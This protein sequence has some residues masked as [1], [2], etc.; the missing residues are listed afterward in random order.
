MDE[1][2]LYSIFFLLLWLIISAIYVFLIRKDEDSKIEVNVRNNAPFAFNKKE[3]AFPIHPKYQINKIQTFEEMVQSTKTQSSKYD[4]LHDELFASNPLP[5][6]STQTKREPKMVPYNTINH[7]TP[8][9]QVFNRR[10]YIFIIVSISFLIA[11]LCRITYKISL[12]ISLI[13]YS[14][15]LLTYYNNKDVKDGEENTHE[16][17]YFRNNYKSDNNPSSWFS[18]EPP[19]DLNIEEQYESVAHDQPYQLADRPRSSLRNSRKTLTD[20]DQKA[21]ECLKKLGITTVMYN[22]YLSNFKSMISQ[23]VLTK[24]IQKLHSEESM[25]ITM[26]SVPGYEHCRGYIIQRIKA[27]A[28]SQYLS[29]HFGDCGDYYEGREWTTD[30][31]S[32]NQIVMHILSVWFSYFMGG[33]NP[34]RFQNLFYEKYLFIKREPIFDDEESVLLCSD[35]YCNFYVYTKYGDNIPEKFYTF[36]GRDSMYA[37]LMLFFW[38][39]MKKKNFLLDAADF[40]ETP[41][42]ID[43]IFSLNK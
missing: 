34:D 25:Y 9:K 42:C 32:D 18:K 17:E 26:L 23:T 2:Y 24:L 31:P 10:I 1:F 33:K 15:A 12:T 38:F 8:P 20:N 3:S 43:R 36:L 19:K 14:L 27:L 28:S 41:M 13:A 29:G 30:S 22:K 4:F 7:R 40:T 6:S 11:F 21:S 35:D 5:I 37:G 39:I 16:D